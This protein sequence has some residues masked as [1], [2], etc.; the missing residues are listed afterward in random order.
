[1]SVADEAKKIVMKLTGMW[2]PDADEG[3]LRD[4]AT[5]WR[6]FADDIE[7]LTAAAN[8][9]ARTLIE[10]NT[11]K[12]ISAF[13]DPF[14]RRYY[15]GN[16]GWLQDM[17]DGARDLATALDQYADTVHNAVTRLEHELEIVGATIVAGTVLAFF[18]A[19]LTE[20]AAAA[21]A[22][23]IVDLSATLGVTVT[24]EVA[25]IAG[26]TL[27]TAAVA[28]VESVTVDL[29]VTQPIAIATGQS[30][31]L[32]LDEAADS[33]LYGMVFGGGL[34]AGGG[35]LKVAAENGSLQSL[36]DGLRLSSADLDA[37]GKSRTWKLFQAPD[38]NIPV[39]PLKPG[40]YDLI[41]GDP[42]YFGQSSTTVG[43]DERTLNNL[44]RVARIPGV[45]DVV[46]HGTDQG[47][48]V[49]GR[50]NAAGKTLT[51][52]EVNPTHIADAIRSNPG[53]HGEPVRLISC[54]SGADARPPELPLAQTLANELGVPVTAP[55]SKVG[56]SA[57]LG[58]N[59][60][61]T[62]GNNG[63]WRIYLPMAQ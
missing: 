12:A 37:M 17:I 50:V 59:Q 46:I 18:T 60:T 34:G 7:T 25:T 61:P 23:E 22:A 63:Y 19:G 48:F 4:A 31:G 58:L 21:A 52:F 13:D 43:Y 41:S 8:T 26:T 5:A 28:G 35:T 33:A 32:N 6:T 45:H 9:T 39:A 62:I 42:V 3:G 55:T 54:Y 44:Q 40:D 57:G 20:A 38:S 27:A 51:D 47:V 2:W 53:Y 16:R 10:N 24:A 36:L 49:P 15:Y 1:M 11:G 14:W 30:N 56:T 29:A